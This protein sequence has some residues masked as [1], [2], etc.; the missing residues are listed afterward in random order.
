MFLKILT[1]NKYLNFSKIININQTLIYFEIDKYFIKFQ[2]ISNH[3]IHI[4]LKMKIF[5]RKI[6][7]NHQIS[8]KIK[9]IIT[10]DFI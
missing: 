9:K 1:S 6:L 5:L 10:I 3:F 7:I 2:K 8:V 4:I